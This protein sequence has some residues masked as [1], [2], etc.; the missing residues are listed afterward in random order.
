MSCIRYALVDRKKKALDKKKA[1]EKPKKGRL[2][3]LPE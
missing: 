3:N 2:T 1:K